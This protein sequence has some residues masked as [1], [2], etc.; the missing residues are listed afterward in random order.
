MGRRKKQKVGNKYFMGFVL[1]P[2]RQHDRVLKIE[3]NDDPVWTGSVRARRFLVDDENAFGGDEREG[4]FKGYISVLDGAVD[5]LKNAYLERVV[6][7]LNSAMRGCVSLVFERPYISANTA[8]LPKIRSLHSN[9][10]G[11]HRG[12]EVET[13]VIDPEVDIDGRA[14]HLQF[15]GSNL[16]SVGAFAESKAAIASFV[17]GLK[18]SGWVNDISVAK[19]DINGFGNAP[20]HIVRYDCDDD[21]YEAIALEVESWTR[22]T[23]NLVINP[24]D[25]QY[26]TSFFSISTPQFLGSILSEFTGSSQAPKKQRHLIFVVSRGDGSAASAA[27]DI[28]EIGST[29]LV[30]AIPTHDFIDNFNFTAD[31][32]VLDNTSDGDL[33]FPTDTATTLAAI[34]RP[35]Q[36]WMDMNPAHIIRCLWTDPV[37]GGPVA[38]ADIG[39]SFAVEAQRYYDEGLGLS[40]KFRGVDEVKADREEIERTADC[41]S[42]LSNLTGK[43]ELVSIRDDYVVDDLLVLDSEIVLDW[44]GLKRPRE[45]EIPNQLTVKYT[46]RDGKSGSVTRTNIAG[47]RRA[48]RIIKATPIDYASVTSVKLATRLCLR[49]LR[50]V[51]SSILSGTIPLKYLPE[52]VEPGSVVKINEPDLGYNNIVMRV[53]D[54]RIGQSGSSDVYASLSEEKFATTQ[55]IALETPELADPRIPVSTEHRLVTEAGYFQGVLQVGQTDL[56]LELEGEPDLGR[57]IATAG[58]T[59]QFQ[60]DAT[61]AINAG[62]NWTDE[63][64]V[65]FEPF[66]VLV[67]DLAADASVTSFVVHYNLTLTEISVGDLARIGT[68]IIRID[69][70]VEILGADLTPEFVTVTCGRGCLDGPPSFHGAGSAFILSSLI[71]P[72]EQSFIAG[73][74]L[75]VKMLSRTG[76]GAQTLG[77]A[78]TDVVTFASRAIRPYSVGNLK[79]DGSFVS[80]GPQSGALTLTWAHRD[81]TFQTTPAVDDFAAANIGPETGVF[82]ETVRQDFY[83]HAQF[84]EPAGMYDRQWLYTDAAVVAE[85]LVNEGTA[86]TATVNVDVPSDVLYDRV[87]FYDPG[88]MYNERLNRTSML[89][90]GV[91]TSRTD[92]LGT[93]ENWITPLVT[94]SPLLPAFDLTAEEV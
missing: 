24:I 41:M 21:D 85:A 34:R 18:G 48:G 80:S 4:G 7:G 46:R 5:Q 37:R 54:T 26:A 81:R 22:G 88:R 12:W 28:A 55:D 23:V 56:D 27:A 10:S 13:A 3:M 64:L 76:I 84:Y 67:D 44:S 53:R 35:F 74:S 1:V 62:V 52:A 86:V 16:T 90:V 73:Q 92:A 38:D 17:R 49:D 70:L 93:Y 69:D 39:A 29:V 66:G 14:I 72:L 87:G 94:V 2:L 83:R 61:L 71:D 78:A 68:E 57:L 11:I 79:V 89:Q 30:T 36:S 42:F 77:E 40:M 6:G 60:L 63:G 19:I 33:S 31:A 82:Y 58:K 91:K 75:S 59:N 32:L 45:S 43:I 15:N 50:T 51:T 47:V 9:V 20:R 65:D 25:M 8:R